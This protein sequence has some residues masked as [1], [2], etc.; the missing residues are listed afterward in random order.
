M[1]SRAMPTHLPFV[2]LR[3]A[4]YS[5]FALLGGGVEQCSHES[6]GHCTVMVDQLSQRAE[7]VFVG[8]IPG[9]TA[10]VTFKG[11]MHS[12]SPLIQSSFTT[13]V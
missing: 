7:F 13:N 12:T 4:I 6:V 10:Q 5:R 8:H 2:L 1:A 3:N 9:K 11:Q